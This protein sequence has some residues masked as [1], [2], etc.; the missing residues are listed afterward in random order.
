MRGKLATQHYTGSVI[1][2]LLDTL[3]DLSTTTKSRANITPP[4]QTYA[5]MVKKS[6]HPHHN[7]VG[8]GKQ[9]VS[10][11]QAQPQLGEYFAQMSGQYNVAGRKQ[12]KQK[13]NPGSGNY[14]K[15][16]MEGNYQ[17]NV[18]TQNRFSFPASGN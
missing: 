1:N 17:F 5:S 6:P 7:R 15:Q 10:P 16:Q 18:E 12:D 8:Y 14:G 11:S 3:P 9:K 4:P 13:V 2:I